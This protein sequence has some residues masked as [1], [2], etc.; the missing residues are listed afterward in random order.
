M[1]DPSE[2]SDADVFGPAPPAA[3]APSGGAGELSD[4]DVFGSPSALPAASLGQSALDVAK[5]LPTGAAVGLESIP[6]IVPSA[7][8]AIGHGVEWGM[9]KLG[10]QSPDAA[11][12]AKQQDALRDS[13]H[14]WSIADVLPKPETTAGQYARTVGEFAPAAVAGPGSLARRVVTQDV[15]PAV[16]SE[17]AGQ[18]TQGTAAEP[19]ARIGAAVVG[20]FP[21]GRWRTAANTSAA[22]LIDDLHDAASNA[23]DQIR[24]SGFALKPKPVATLA[25]QI[26][27]ELTKRGWTERNVPE[28]YGVIRDLQDLHNAPA[29]STV[30]ASNFDTARQELLQATRNQANKREGG[31]AWTAIGKIDDYLSN[32]PPGHVASGDAAAA[33]DLFD[34]ARGNWAAMKRLEMAN[35]KVELGALNA[36]TAHS[37]MNTDNAMRQAI[38]QLIRPNKYG[39]TL[40]EQHGFSDDEIGMMGDIAK[41]TLTRNTL[42]YVGN[43]LGGGGGFGQLGLTAAGMG[44]GYETGNPEYLALPALGVAARYGAGK[45]AQSD[46]QRLLAQV[47]RRSPLGAGTP[48]TLPSQAQ[49]LIGAGALRGAAPPV[50]GGL[51]GLPALSGPAIGRAQDQQDVPGPEQQQKRGG[52]VQQKAKGGAVGHK[53]PVGMKKVAPLGRKAKDGR[54]YLPD[55]N[56]PGK[57]LMVVRK[58]G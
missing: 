18:A 6:G 36:E 50:S 19:Y 37:G 48:A 52:A 4:A 3:P 46:A 49:R 34:E 53:G 1:A 42:R 28:T 43:L 57:W 24:Q 23:Y 44:L 10:L 22:P 32:V 15:A 13:I 55:K 33:S 8:G 20:G 16:A 27:Q 29:G 5:Q 25:D 12:A 9:N 21:F 39:K 7:L 30:T 14:P 26:E 11:D 54:Y 17:A 41:G 31:A 58:A 51:P 40:A 38:K 56:R 2:L 47:A 35:G 45:L